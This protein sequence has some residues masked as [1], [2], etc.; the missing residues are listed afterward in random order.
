MK[1]SFSNY[2]SNSFS[3]FSLE[4]KI[5]HALKDSEK[6]LASIFFAHFFQVPQRAVN[7][8]LRDMRRQKSVEI[9]TKK[10]VSYWII[11]GMEK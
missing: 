4:A 6:P 1:N 11:R 2:K 5:L 8:K 3:A 7:D 10:K 9:V